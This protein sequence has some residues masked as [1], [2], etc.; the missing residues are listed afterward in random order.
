MKLHFILVEPK[1]PENIGAAARAIKVMGAGRLLLVNPLCPL[2][3]KALWVAHGSEE[4]IHEAPLFH[5]L[6]QALAGCDF[7]VATTAKSRSVKCDPVSI[8]EL[9]QFLIN[10]RS[11]DDTIAIVFGREESGLTNEEISLC[12]VAS[13]IP[14]AI[15]FP[16]VNLA[17]AVMLYAYELSAFA[18]APGSGLKRNT[19]T[20]NT[21]E[22][23]LHLLKER[24]ALVLR[25]TGIPDNDA[26]HGRI[27]ER[28]SHLSP[29]DQRLMLTVA[30][31]LLPHD[32]EGDIESQPTKEEKT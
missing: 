6:E 22:A 20:K 30:G 1:V 14:M 11:A 16:S 2:D 10:K 23:P 12:D 8:G 9:H 24:V 29:S 32:I 3:G 31:K 17:Q 26:R 13:F 27:M 4:L 28:V 15:P 25:S 18:N 21:G 7:S 19:K 5:S